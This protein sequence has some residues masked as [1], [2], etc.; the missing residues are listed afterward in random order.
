MS[1]RVSN[2]EDHTRPIQGD[3][4]AD[5]EDIE[6]HVILNVS[7]APNDVA[8]PL[9]GA[10]SHMGNLDPSVNSNYNYLVQSTRSAPTVYEARV[11]ELNGQNHRVK[12]LTPNKPTS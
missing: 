11:S 1:A 12:T 8:P 2:I 6:T 4:T 5:H 10:G 3:R 7:Q 9:G